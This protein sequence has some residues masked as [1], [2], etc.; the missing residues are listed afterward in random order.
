MSSA[1]LA[2]QAWN[3]ETDELDLGEL[4]PALRTYCPMLYRRSQEEPGI[5]DHPLQCL[6]LLL[7]G[8]EALYGGAAGGGKS[9]ALLA[10]AL[11]YV[12][13]PGYSALI[14]RRTYTQLTQPGML[15]PLADSW[16]GPTDAVRSEEGKKWTFPS[17]AVLKFGHVKDEQAAQNYQGGA[18]H[19]VGFDELA[20]FTETQ[21][22]YIAFSRQ[23]RDTRMQEIGVPIR[24]RASANP[25]GI[26]QTWVKK[27]FIDAKTRPEAVVFVPAKVRDN[28]GLD[29]DDYEK[30]MGHLGET[31]R[32]QLMDGDWGAFEGA[33]YPI[34]DRSIHVVPQMD[35]PDTWQRWEAMDHGVTNPTAW[36]LFASDYDGNVILADT[37]YAP[38]LPEEHSEVI[39]ARRADWWQAR[40]DGWPQTHPAYGDPMSLR[41]SLPIQ[42]DFGQPLSLQEHYQKLGIRLIPANNR[43]KVG[44]IEILSRLKPDPTRRFPLWHPKAGQLG[45][46]SLFIVETCVETIDQLENAPLASGEHDPNR[47]EA[48]DAQWES[49]N[50][51]G[52]AMVRYGLTQR[53]SASEEPEQEPEDPRQAMLKRRQERNRRGPRDRNDYQEL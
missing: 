20:Q 53:S 10:A 2:R 52:H 36:G 13:V 22:K 3:P 39:K 29:A 43:R 31:L 18:Y 48:V 24:V 5:H 50:G 45:A 26:G 25:G 11:Q 15:I 6:F 27:R 12:D 46:P 4:F 33:A 28:P 49:D 47:G 37:H 17:G 23:R 40:E 1:L 41:E 16:L 42:N 38:G 34:F 14:L 19:Y 7:D 21:Y 44:F 9:V 32:K 30:S 35:L 51:H 8:R